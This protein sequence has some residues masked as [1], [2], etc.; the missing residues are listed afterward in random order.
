MRL[1]H[2]IFRFLMHVKVKEVYLQHVC[3]LRPVRASLHCN[4]AFKTPKNLSRG[5][6]ICTM[7]CVTCNEGRVSVSN[8]EH[9]DWQ[10]LQSP[11]P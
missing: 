3:Q 2:F 4:R 8:R 10:A 5:C 7:L 1:V 6:K 11:R 9:S